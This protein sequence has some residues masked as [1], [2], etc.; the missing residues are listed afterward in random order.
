MVCANMNPRTDNASATTSHPSVP[1]RKLFKPSL[2][3]D[4]RP[5]ADLIILPTEEILVTDVLTVQV[6]FPGAQP[7]GNSHVNRRFDK[8]VVVITSRTDVPVSGEVVRVF[9][10][11]AQAQINA[12]K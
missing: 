5:D 9:V 2:E 4:R 8:P 11:G 1:A 7:P 10:T 12:V 6:I 3:P